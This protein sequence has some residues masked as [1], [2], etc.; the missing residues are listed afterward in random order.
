MPQIIYV[1]RNGTRIMGECE[2]ERTTFELE[3]CMR[4]DYR[5]IG[6][7]RQQQWVGGYGA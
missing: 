6:R 4:R 7:F 5:E 3:F 2:V 1:D